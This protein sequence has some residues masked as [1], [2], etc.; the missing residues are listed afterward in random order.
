MMRRVPRIIHACVSWEYV[1]CFHVCPRV[2]LFQLG[3][4]FIRGHKCGQLMGCQIKTLV[5]EVG[6]FCFPTNIYYYLMEGGK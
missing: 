1:A 4:T 3:L 6:S 2:V 5:G